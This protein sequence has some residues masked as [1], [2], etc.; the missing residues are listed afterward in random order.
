MISVGLNLMKRPLGKARENLEFI[1]NSHALRGITARHYRPVMEA[2]FFALA[3]LLGLQW[4]TDVK[5]AWVQLYSF[6]V[7][8]HGTYCAFRGF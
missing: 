5:Q 3:K 6:N 1:A 7:R 8:S 2:L 4:T